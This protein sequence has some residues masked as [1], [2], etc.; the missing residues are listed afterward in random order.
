MSDSKIAAIGP[1]EIIQGFRSL[2]IS[3]FDAKN[4]S[5]ASEKILDL[6][7]KAEEDPS[8]SFAIVIVIEELLENLPD[9]EHQRLTAGETMPAII[10]VPGIKGGSKKGLLKLKKLTEKAIGSDILD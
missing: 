5:E 4:S 9:E 10:L 8:R 7:R 2:G 1:I 6:K 3:V